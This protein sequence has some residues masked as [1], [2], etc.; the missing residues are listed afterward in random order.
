MGEPKGIR[1]KGRDCEILAGM[2]GWR[3]S[4]IQRLETGS[5]PFSGRILAGHRIDR[6]VFF[7]RLLGVRSRA[8]DPGI[9][10]RGSV[11]SRDSLFAQS[12]SRPPSRTEMASKRPRSKRRQPFTCVLTLEDLKTKTE[13]TITS[14]NERASPAPPSASKAGSGPEK[15]KGPGGQRNSLKRLDSAKEIK[16]NPRIFL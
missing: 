2:K 9:L 12:G 1:L 7:P 14:R 16:G 5:G 8:Y 11:D 4:A 13:G 10:T 3:P 6:P 15:K